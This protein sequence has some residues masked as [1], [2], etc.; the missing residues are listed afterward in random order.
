TFTNAAGTAGEQNDNP[1]VLIG[2][3]TDPSATITFVDGGG[4][5]IANPVLQNGIAAT[6]RVRITQSGNGV[7]YTDVA[8]PTCFSSPTN[9]TATVSTGGNPYAAP[10]VT[11]GFIRLSNGALALNGS[12]TVQFDTTPNCT[13]GVYTVTSDPSTNASNPPSGTNQ[14]VSTTGGSLTVAAGRA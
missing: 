10:V 4:T 9:V 14:S 8:V 1:P 6:V 12:L 7:K 13:S 5:P 3:I 11:D 2:H